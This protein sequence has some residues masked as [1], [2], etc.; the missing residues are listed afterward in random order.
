MKGLVLESNA[1]L[2]F[3]SDRAEPAAVGSD[4]VR[5][6]VAA[7]GICGSDIPRA[8]ENGAYHYPLVLGHEFSAVV[9]ESGHGYTEGDPVAVFPLIPLSHDTPRQ[10]GDYAL[11]REYDYFGSRRDGG[12]QEILQAP[13]ANLVRVPHGVNLLHAAMTEP[14]AVALHA[15][16]KMKILAGDTGFVAG[17]G[18]IGNLAAQWLRI[19]GCRR[20]ILSDVDDRKLGIARD[21]GFETVNSREED[22]VAHVRAATGGEGAARVIEACGLPVAFRQALD[23]AAPQ[24]DVVFLG[25]LHGTFQIEEKAFSSILRRELTIHGTWNSKVV[26]TG[27]DDWSTVL[28]F[29]D[30]ELIVAP[31]ITD[32]PALE[33][34]PEIFESV[35]GRSRF[36]NK[37]I[38]KILAS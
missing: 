22:P 26:P 36:H 20:V 14:A 29:M 12:M 5:L 9:A 4:P 31:L 27:Q 23:A 35:R 8:F 30:R 17:A 1:N 25:N 38:F 37:V 10:T 2:R 32:T 34:G 11:C 13:A 21:M 7:C 3:R 28:A 24:G 33:E 18:P 19:H 16:R 6:R 15:V